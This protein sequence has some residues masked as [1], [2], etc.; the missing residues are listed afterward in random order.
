MGVIVKITSLLHLFVIMNF[1][2]MLS[3]MGVGDKELSEKSKLLLRAVKNG[4]QNKVQEL[5]PSIPANHIDNIRDM[6]E[7]G[8]TL[9]IK[10]VRSGNSYIAHMLL[11]KGA[12]PNEKDLRGDAAL[13]WAVRLANL[14]MVYILL[15]NK[16]NPNI[17]NMGGESPLFLAAGSYINE[18]EHQKIIKMLLDNGA[19]VNI[20]NKQG[21][22]ALDVASGST[23]SLLEQ[24]NE[25]IE[26][27]DNKITGCDEAKRFVEPILSESKRI[28][29]HTLPLGSRNPSYIDIG[30][31]WGMSTVRSFL[32]GTPSLKGAVP[33]EAKRKMLANIYKIHL[34]PKSKKDLIEILRLLCDEAI[35]DETFKDSI[36]GLKFKC[37]LDFSNVQSLI[38]SLKSPMGEVFPIIVMYAEYK[39]EAAEYVLNKCIELFKNMK[40]SNITPRYNKKITSLIYYAQGNGDDKLPHFA[41]YFTQDF[42]FY[43]PDF[44]GQGRNE[45]YE[46]RIN[47]ENL[48][49]IQ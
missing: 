29:L 9:L 24:K 5:L 32:E 48:K 15:K 49:L 13:I 20:R 34:M 47:P 42:I 2:G 8:E 3:I 35:K 16:A 25:E 10:A 11:K 28:S 44:E 37:T 31:I 4:D 1:F 43:K 46:L 30:G 33:D 39:K 40:G 21:K 26:E 22:T 12:N 14:N 27:I 45:N 23:R 18:A 6:S 41:G 7:N 17:Q 38:N 19:D 36:L